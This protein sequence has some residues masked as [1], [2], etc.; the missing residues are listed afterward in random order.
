MRF[1]AARS[2]FAVSQYDGHG[3]QE[4]SEFVMN[5]LHMNVIAAWE[6]AGKPSIPT[7]DAGKKGHPKS[8]GDT[9]AGMRA[10]LENGFSRTEAGFM[11]QAERQGLNAGTTAVAV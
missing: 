11:E 5:K 2:A 1:L 9:P 3:G 6:D 10:I 7:A 4:A 8:V